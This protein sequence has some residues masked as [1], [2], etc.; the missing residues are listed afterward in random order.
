MTRVYYANHSRDSIMALES[1]D[2]VVRAYR[3]LKLFDDLANQPENMVLTKMREG[4]GFQI[5]IS[6][7][8]PILICSMILP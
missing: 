6:Y 8:I 3:A 5:I 1:P 4:T 2:E 7:F